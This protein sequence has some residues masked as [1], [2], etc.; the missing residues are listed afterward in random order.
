MPTPA[1]IA[2]STPPACYQHILAQDG[3]SSILDQFSGQ[4]AMKPI[5]PSAWNRN[6]AKLN[7]AYTE[8]YEVRYTL[9]TPRNTKDTLFGGCG[10]THDLATVHHKSGQRL[11]IASRRTWAPK[12]AREAS[13]ATDC[14]I[15]IPYEAHLGR[16]GLC[17]VGIRFPVP[18]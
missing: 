16:K 13:G 10:R 1:L 5:H 3:L 9:A 15:S 6:S 2:M 7:F 14:R 11:R 4:A 12:G 8:F 18:T 17:V